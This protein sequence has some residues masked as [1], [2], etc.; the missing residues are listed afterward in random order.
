MVKDI[1][2]LS[3]IISTMFVEICIDFLILHDIIKQAVEV[4]ESCNMIALKISEKL[5]GLKCLK[6][7]I[8]KKKDKVKRFKRKVFLPWYSLGAITSA[9][10]VGLTIAGMFAGGI[11]GVIGSYCL[12]GAAINNFLAITANTI[13][14]YKLKKY[15]EQLNKCE[16]KIKF[17]EKQLQQED[18]YSNASPLKADEN[19]K[20]LKDFYDIMYHNFNK[21]KERK[22]DKKRQKIDQIAEILTEK[23]D[24][25]LVM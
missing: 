19:K 10:G 7:K 4:G 9:V 2:Y 17:A 3:N 23:Q 15:G 22:R 25:G 6:N 1:P 12:L 24:S 21:K 20:M 16:Q 11:L 18:K 14:E 13:T 5:K 8:K